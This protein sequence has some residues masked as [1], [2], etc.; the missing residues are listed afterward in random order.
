MR[1]L[2]ILCFLSLSIQSIGQDWTDKTRVLPDDLRQVPVAIYVMHGP[3]PNYP[4]LAVKEDRN[5]YKYVWRHST[6]IFSPDKELEV[7]Q[8]GSYIWYSEKGWMKNV[9]YN[10]RKFAKQ[11]NCP[12]G[13]LKPGVHYTF[14]K[15]Y[16]WGNDLYGGDALW[17]VIA[18][19]EEGRIYKGIGLLETESEVF[20]NEK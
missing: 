5:G 11:F 7:I 2:V 17:Y 3:N 12:K 14:E 1:S 9:D 16:R 13:I 8:A 6:T 20:N 19:D 15:N 18:E 4:E 10:K